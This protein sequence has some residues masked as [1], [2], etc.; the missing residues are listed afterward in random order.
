MNLL[1]ES[2]DAIRHSGRSRP[3]RLKP[4]GDSSIEGYEPPELMLDESGMIQ[5]CNKSVEN[6][7]GYGL[8]ELVW[9]H[10]SCLFPEFSGI[11]IIQKG[12]IKPT[13]NFISRCGHLFMGLDRQGNT[14]PNELNFIR[15][16]HQG[17]RTLRLILRPRWD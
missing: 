8:G 1:L 16:E 6:L 11:E 3:V 10:I 4:P 5:D 15:L 14:I 17:M 12:E 7:F 2:D 9:Q 13:I